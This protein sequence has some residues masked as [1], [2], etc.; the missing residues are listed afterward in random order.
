M[1]PVS[2]TIHTASTG[3]LD[4]VLITRLAEQLGHASVLVCTAEASEPPRS[5]PDVK[6]PL[7]ITTI[8]PES[9]LKH[10]QSEAFVVV[11]DCMEQL[12]MESA[13]MLLGRLRNLISPNILVIT[14]R[15]S[16]WQLT[17]FIAM[18]FKGITSPHLEQAGY[19][20]YYYDIS[21]YNHKR[22]WNNAQFWANP[23]NFNKFRW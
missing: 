6:D 20:G 8:T 10:Q 15:N 17:D 13:S 14:P 9:A 1:S 22:T 23:E 16:L 2:P 3:Q 18:G 19:K 12:P 7:R 4:W 11:Y 21:S 5:V